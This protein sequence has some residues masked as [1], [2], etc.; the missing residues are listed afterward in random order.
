MFGLGA[1]G[2]GDIA[3]FIH[4]QEDDPRAFLRAFEVRG[5]RIAGGGGEQPGEHGALRDIHLG[6]GAAEIA[7]GRGLKPVGARAQ[8]GTVHVDGEDFIL[9][10]AG[11]HGEG[12]EHFLDLPRHGALAAVCLVVGLVVPFVGVIRHAEAEELRGLLGQGRAAVARERSTPLAQVDA[13]RRG[14]AARGD[15]QVAVEAFVLC[16]DDRVFEMGGDR[17]SGDL[18]AKLLTAPGKDIAATV[19]KRHRAARPPIQ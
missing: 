9:G 7:L 14:D 13:N 8:I 11:L 6:G 5:W 2:V 19:Q 3:L 15:A 17:V 4:Q 18:A 10:I 16:G 1:L 12:V